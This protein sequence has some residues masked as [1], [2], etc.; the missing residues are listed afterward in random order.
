MNF[1][2]VFS[3]VSLMASLSSIAFA[4]LAFKR[5]DKAEHKTDGKTEGVMFSDIGYIKACVDRVEKNLTKVDER[6]R[7]IAERLAKV[8]ESVRNVTKRVDEIY[9]LDGT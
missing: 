3:L 1:E 6:D 5:S 4:Y 2:V 9:K 7:N 8:E